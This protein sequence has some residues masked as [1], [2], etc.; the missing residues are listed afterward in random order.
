VAKGEKWGGRGSRLK[1]MRER[2][3]CNKKKV[4]KIKGGV[5]KK[6][7]EEEEIKVVIL[8]EGRGT[9]NGKICLVR[10][11][12]QKRTWKRVLGTHHASHLFYCHKMEQTTPSLTEQAEIGGVRKTEK[13]RKTRKHCLSF[14]QSARVRATGEGGEK[15]NYQIFLEIMNLGLV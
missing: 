6:E 5:K 13:K 14:H 15:N 7:N 11:H 10:T 8:R 4:A 1:G 9:L 12:E 2:S 3:P